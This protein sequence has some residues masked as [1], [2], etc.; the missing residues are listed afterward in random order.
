MPIVRLVVSRVPAAKRLRMTQAQLRAFLL[1]QGLPDVPAVRQ[2]R[3][4]S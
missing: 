3:R 1:P 4:F 2:P